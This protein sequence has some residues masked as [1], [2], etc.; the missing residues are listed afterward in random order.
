M[1]CKDCLYSYTKTITDMFVSW[2]AHYVVQ[3]QFVCSSHSAD[4]KWRIW[5][6][7]LI[8]CVPCWSTGD[9]YYIYLYTMCF[10]W[11]SCR[12]QL[13]WN[14][15][16]RRRDDDDAT[17]GGG[18]RVHFL[19]SP[20]FPSMYDTNWCV[21]AGKGALGCYIMG[22]LLLEISAIFAVRARRLSSRCMSTFSPVCPASFCVQQQQIASVEHVKPR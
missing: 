14:M 16:W 9:I 12:P 22:L 15:E 6:D 4:G 13:M 21:G 20:D 11:R 5:W 8:V 1:L 2:T 3:P 18:A 7:D 10:W 19:P 17:S